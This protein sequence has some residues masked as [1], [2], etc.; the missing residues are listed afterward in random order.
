[1][2][3]F[4]HIQMIKQPSNLSINLYPHQLASVYSMEFLEREKKII[5]EDSYIQT[6]IGINADLTGYG[7]SLSMVALILRDKMPWDI[8]TDYITEEVTAMACQHIKKINQKRFKKINTTLILAGPS[9]CKQWV[10]EFS[11]TDLRVGEVFT[12]KSACNI[13]VH[14]YDVVIVTLT[15]FNRFVERYHNMA[16]KRFIFDEPGHLRVPSMREVR[17][18]FTWFVTATPDRILVT[19]RKCTGSY[20]YKIV[21]GWNDFNRFVYDITLQNDDD[22]IRASFNMPVTHHAYYQCYSPV[23]NA[24]NGLVS[25]KINKMIQASNISGAIQ[26]LGGKRTDNIID[27]VMNRKNLELEE[28]RSKIHIWELRSDEKKVNEWKEREKRILEQMNILSERFKDILNSNCVICREQLNKPVMEPNCQNIFC[29]NCLLTW[30]K[31]HRSCPMCRKDIDNKELVYIDTENEPISSV[32]EDQQPTK[33]QMII[34]LINNNKNG[35]FIIFSDWDETF[36]SI[37]S[38]LK[39]HKIS[40]IE[41]KGTVQTR[42][43]ALEKYKNGNVNVVFLNSR[44]NGSGINMQ[45]T[46]DIILY[47]QMDEDTTTQIIGRANRIGRTQS[48]HVHHLTN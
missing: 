16:W 42:N 25:D 24:I 37:R 47:H 6:D 31:Q 22:F 8:T 19:H 34:K 36:H 12:R 15:M 2:D 35:R 30:L 1:M 43:R 5:G 17:A 20:M 11:Y 33:E 18:G 40:F 46:T 3:T 26:C 38:L 10:K 7:K 4:E 45:E 13:D 21:G 48:L 39:S 32:D 29:G 41:V 28:I 14:Q 9:V 23:Y 27:L 44:F